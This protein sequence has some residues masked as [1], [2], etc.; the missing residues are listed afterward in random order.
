MPNNLLARRDFLKLCSLSLS[1]LALHHFLS[2]EK[3]TQ[4]PSEAVGL[5]RV[6][7]KEINIYEEPTYESE[8]VD[9]RKKDELIYI[10]EKLVSPIGP[11]YNPRWYH[12]D[13]GFAHTA[14]LQPVETHQ[15]DIVYEIPESG[16][17]A[18]VTV[19][20][21]L[22]FRYTDF[23]GWQPLYRLYYQSM[24]WV[25]G[26]GYGPNH[27]A[28]YQITDDLLNINYHVPAW[29]M[30]FIDPEEVTPLSTDVPPEEKRV[31]VNLRE[32]TLSAFESNEVVLHT[33]VSTGMLH[34]STGNG[35]STKTP[36]G[37]FHVEIK[38]P[39]RHMGDGNLTSDIY[40]YELPGVPW[41]A[42]F[43]KTGVAFH[44]TYWHDNYGNEMSHG[45]VNM[46]PDEAKWLWRWLT[47]VSTHTDRKV[48]GYGTLVE[49]VY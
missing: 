30:R 23:Y 24:H 25:T 12:I 44:G 42:Y 29:H 32:Q 15:N 34:G 43:Y 20:I 21:S 22:S 28:W 49:V 47:P 26:I 14:Y 48:G 18:E 11:D 40:A 17:I 31:L 41:V 33:K 3:N 19:P 4:K 13:G 27:Q 46:K 6:T 37:T 1:S 36:A 16:H 10:Y 8:V 35:I 5:A 45:C 2:N 38:M 9:T 39:V 7:V